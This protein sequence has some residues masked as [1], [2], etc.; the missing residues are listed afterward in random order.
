MIL[1]NVAAFCAGAACH[2]E[3]YRRPVPAL[4]TEFYLWVSFGGVIGGIFAALLAP[5][6]FNRIYEYPILCCRACSRCLACSPAVCAAFCRIRPVL[7]SP[8][9]RSCSPC[10]DLR[11]PDG[12]NCRFGSC[13]S[14][15]WPDAVLGA[16]AR[17]SS[18]LRRGL[19]HH[20]P[21]GSRASTD[22]VMRSFF[23]VHHIVETS[24]TASAALSRHHHSWRGAD[25]EADGT[26]V[27]GSPKP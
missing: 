3:L 12:R 21:P 10:F 1:V 5:Y 22:R 20:R 8:R 26:P 7:G 2:G 14:R 15:W 23:G 4:L 24:D 9:W 25:R 19:R 18:R 6:I 13:W 16:T 17:A 11:L 27:S